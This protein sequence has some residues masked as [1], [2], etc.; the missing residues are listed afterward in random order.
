MWYDVDVS[1]ISTA[2][3]TIRVEADSPEDANE[4]AVEKAHDTDFGGCV[5]DYDFEV[6]GIMEAT[7]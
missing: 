2:T 5:V 7:G 6:N 4:K 3:L 1:R